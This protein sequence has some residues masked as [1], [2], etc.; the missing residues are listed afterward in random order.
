M[1]KGALNKSSVDQV[2]DVAEQRAAD[3]PKCESFESFLRTQAKVKT[4][5]GSYVDYTFE[6]REALLEIV[7]LIDRIIDPKNPLPD[8]RVGICGGAQIGKTIIELWLMGYM[9]GQQFLNAILYLPDD[10]MVQ[11]IVDAKFR[12]DVL[13]QLPWLNDLISL[14]K[15]VN[16][17]G[18]TVNRKGAF[19][20]TDGTRSANG[21]LR[22]MNKVPTSF[23]ADVVIEDE[24]DDIDPKNSKYLG[25][26]M[27]ASKLRLAISIGTQRIQGAGQNKVFEEGTQH[28]WNLFAASGA[29]IIPEEHWP[30]ICRL[31]IDGTPK[32]TDPKLTA[33]GFKADN[34]AVWS[35][36]PEAKVYLA[37][38]QTGEPLDRRLGKF[39]AKFPERAKQRN[40]SFRVTQLSTAAIDLIQIVRAYLLE[41]VV[42]PDSMIVFNC[43]RLGI[44]KSGGLQP[45]TREVLDRARS[46]V[47]Y[48]VGLKKST[49]TAARRV[50]GLDMGD[51]CWFT[52]REKISALDVRMPWVEQMSSESVRNRI[53][54]LRELLGFDCLFVDAG[55]LRD[56]SRALCFTLN[57]LDSFKAPTILNPEKTRIDFGNGLIWDGE[58][59]RWF[60]LR[61]AAVEFT[62]KSGQGVVH[63]LGVTQ[64]G[65][66][67]PIIACNREETIA[68]LV[69]EL[70]TPGE[71][72]I[73]VVDGKT[74]VDPKLRLAQKPQGSSPI[75]QTLDDHFVQGGRRAP[76]A[77]GDLE[78]IDKCE[79]HFLLS[80]AYGRLAERESDPATHA[81]KPFEYESVTIKGH[82]RIQTQKGALI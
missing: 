65:R 55:P 40:W 46:V 47:R 37:H 36:D 28:C 64:D 62:L 12:P 15:S 49:E 29:Q 33:E 3:A 76:N 26:R 11:G 41:A 16:E 52:C 13:D 71:G 18:K 48:E 61:C 73:E 67:Y 6:G 66:M 69:D 10:D 78:F 14:G 54:Q 72:I 44:P 82:E 39:I 42:D 23:S 20:V 56:L 27:T 25:G 32:P 24:K 22:G 38:P 51:R 58:K 70:L 9:T 63:K 77:K 45:I 74:R 34:G 81:R 4:P 57:G 7:Q 68:H 50:A 43:D 21:M 1:K 80:S 8:S 2:L 35:Y 19:N 31:A 79:N 5:G 59:Q 17:S 75:L 30:E 53:P 60:G